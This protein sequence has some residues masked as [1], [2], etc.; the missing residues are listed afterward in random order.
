MYNLKFHKN[1]TSER[2][3]KFNTSQQI[4]MIANELNR[5][6][7]SLLRRD[8]EEVRECYERAME[9]LDLTISISLK[10]SKRK[11]LLRFREVLGFEY[12]SKEKKVSRIEALTK[13]LIL[14]DKEAFNLLNP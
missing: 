8:E 12:L 6:K 2:W 5:A 9:L 7:N 3:A 10:R 4:L 11:E 14:L 1:L 13:T